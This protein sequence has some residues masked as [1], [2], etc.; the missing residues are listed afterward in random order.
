[1]AL[2]TI[3]HC[4]HENF[5]KIAIKLNFLNISELPQNA[6]TNKTILNLKCIVLNYFPTIEMHKFLNMLWIWYTTNSNL[7]IEKVSLPWHLPLLLLVYWIVI[8]PWIKKLMR[9]EELSNASE[10]STRAQQCLTIVW[11]VPLFKVWSA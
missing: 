4:N 3:V 5:C 6:E 9:F 1:M 7:I 8:N 2:P 11:H 10:L